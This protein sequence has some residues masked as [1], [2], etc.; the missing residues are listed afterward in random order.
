M[1]LLA[2][3]H[4][5]PES[6]RAR[7][8]KALDDGSALAVF[9]RLVE[10]QGG[11]AATIDDPSKLPAAANQHVLTA[12]NAGTVTRVAARSI[13]VAALRLGAGRTRVQDEIDPGAGIDVAVR[14][15][16]QVEKGEP[17][18]TLLYND[19]DPGL[20]I[21]LAEAAIEIAAEDSPRAP[22]SRIISVIRDD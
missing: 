13:G 21:E 6:A 10:A 1:L 19:R 16:Q 5:D 7:I 2:K 18:A 3:T 14:V 11:D 4:T 12:S 8:E 22:K 17:L 15:G 9:R 20:A